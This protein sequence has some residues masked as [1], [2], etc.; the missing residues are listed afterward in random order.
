VIICSLKVFAYLPTT[1]KH[2]IITSLATA[3][4]DN[5]R[6]IEGRDSAARTV[7]RVAAVERSE[8]NNNSCNDNGNHAPTHLTSVRNPYSEV[9]NFVYQSILYHII[10]YRIIS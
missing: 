9:L 4:T 8:G 7:E 3:Q 5:D 1:Q 2:L 10:V 6:S